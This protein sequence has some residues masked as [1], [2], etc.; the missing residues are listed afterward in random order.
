MNTVTNVNFQPTLR[1][2]IELH[3][4]QHAKARKQ[5]RAIS[6]GSVELIGFFGERTHDGRGGIRCLMTERA[7]AKMERILGHTQRM[8]NLKG[9]YVVLSAEDECTVI[10][11]GHLYV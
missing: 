10:T 9:C 11:V 1:R 5:Q 3:L 4:G 7:V 8:A 2:K 6:T